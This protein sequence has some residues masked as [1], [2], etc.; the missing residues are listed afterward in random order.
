MSKALH[1]SQSCV[2]CGEP[3][4]TLTTEIKPLKCYKHKPLP[5]RKTIKK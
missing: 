4:A 2:I 5:K 1:I 3:I